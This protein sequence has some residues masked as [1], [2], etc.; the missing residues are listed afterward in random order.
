MVCGHSLELNV[1]S[2]LEMFL[3]LSQLQLIQQLI[4]SN[5][6]IFGTSEKNKEVDNSTQLYYT[7]KQTKAANF[8]VNSHLSFGTYRHNFHAIL[9]L[10]F[11]KSCKI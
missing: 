1:T 10:C 7:F 4:L 8:A 9:Q 5:M 6:T 3:S 11:Q 2:A